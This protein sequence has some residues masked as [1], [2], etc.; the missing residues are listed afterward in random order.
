[1]LA[2]MASGQIISALTAE[3][4]ENQALETEQWRRRNS[5]A[6]GVG[7]DGSGAPVGS[8]ASLRDP[9]DR[10]SGAR[11]TDRQGLITQMKDTT[12]KG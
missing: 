2:T 12:L 9:A 8:Y 1:M 4:P 10:N 3:D 7:G 11:P 5:T 6:F